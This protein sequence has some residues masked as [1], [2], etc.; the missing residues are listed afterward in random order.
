MVASKMAAS[1]SLEERPFHGLHEPPI[2]ELPPGGEK[3]EEKL[4]E[5]AKDAVTQEK[6]RKGTLSLV[7]LKKDYSSCWRVP[8]HFLSRSFVVQ[9]R[10]REAL[11]PFFR[12]GDFSIIFGNQED[13]DPYLQVIEIPSDCASFL[14]WMNAC[15]YLLIELKMHEL[16]FA[17][18][19]ALEETVEAMEVERGTD[20]FSEEAVEVCRQKVWKKSLREWRR[21][22]VATAEYPPP[23]LSSTAASAAAAASAAQQAEFERSVK[24][25]LRRSLREKNMSD[26]APLAAAVIRTLSTLSLKEAGPSV[27]S[28]TVLQLF[29]RIIYEASLLVDG[30]LHLLKHMGELSSILGVSA[31]KF[32]TQK[33][34][35]TLNLAEK[36]E[37]GRESCVP[38]CTAASL[39]QL[40]QGGTLSLN[41]LLPIQDTKTFFLPFLLGRQE[42]APLLSSDE[43]VFHRA[44]MLVPWLGSALLHEEGKPRLTLTGGFLCFCRSLIAKGPEPSDVDLFCDSQE[45]LEAASRRVQRCMQAHTRE[46]VIV[47]QVNGSRCR[48]FVQ[49]ATS[50]CWKCDVYVN[51]ESRVTKYHLAQVRCCLRLTEKNEVELLLSP[52]AAVAWVTMVSLDFFDIKGSK[53]PEEIL[54]SYWDKGFNVCLT[55]G[56][57]AETCRHLHAT[58]QLAYE[59]SKRFRRPERLSSFR[60]SKHLV[61]TRQASEAPEEARRNEA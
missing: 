3:T 56:Q 19:S 26:L 52:S 18:S 50:F 59:V 40:Y 38:L 39:Q 42:V 55:Q 4:E 57:H 16:A 43:A 27:S 20:P 54:A 9:K 14:K 24:S 37:V 25:K 21:Q 12:P 48:V 17:A 7:L 51:S 31:V 46:E 33:C 13:M 10:A 60:P 34:L 11:E 6:L 58:R 32:L 22:E 61:V 5:L 29:S 2:E 1:S 44:R 49:S 35:G 15:D 28:T 30:A 36:L 45:L 53:A 8:L 41:S 47:E 23:P